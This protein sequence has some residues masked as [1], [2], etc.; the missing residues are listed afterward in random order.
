MN[1]ELMKSL[2]GKDREWRKKEGHRL[3]ES[4]RPAEEQGH[5]HLLFGTLCDDDRGIGHLSSGKPLKGFGFSG[6]PERSID[7][8]GEVQPDDPAGA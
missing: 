7:P 8:H 4:S 2:T 5:R 3:P 6:P 1:H